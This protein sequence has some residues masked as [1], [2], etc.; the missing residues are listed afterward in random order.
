[1]TGTGYVRRARSGGFLVYHKSECRHARGRPDAVPVTL[2]EVNEAL[3]HYANFAGPVNFEG[4]T[5][6]VWPCGVCLR[7][8]PRIRWPLT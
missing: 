7:A 4:R 6:Y 1:M 3:A 5:F 2:D 8:P